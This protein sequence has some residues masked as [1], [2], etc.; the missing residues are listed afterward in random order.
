MLQCKYRSKNNKFCCN[1]AI[2]VN[3]I[4]YDRCHIKSH[5]TD[6]SQ[7]NSIKERLRENFISST[8]NINASNIINTRGDG[9]CLYRTM[10]K[11]LLDNKDTLKK[12][13]FIDVNVLDHED[14]DQE[15]YI[16]TKIQDE[17][18]NYIYENKSKFI[19]QCGELL[20]DVVMN[21]HNDTISDIEEYHELYKI[22]AGD[23]DYYYETTILDNGRKQKNKIEISDRWGS[24]AE[25]I[26]F[27]LRFGIE[28]N[29]FIIQ[30]FDERKIK[31]IEVTKRAKDIRLKLYQ[32]INPEFEGINVNH[33][34]PLNLIIEKHLSSPHYMYINNLE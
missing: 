12:Y 5:W 10:A 32:K 13:N 28:V 17:L 4:T 6:I 22:F 9:A 15:K 1:K 31:I 29:V 7:F 34:K 2:S 30:K 21:T 8:F 20:E 33:N 24:T 26:A 11:Y 23:N 25:Q 27:S 16:A 3:G 18:N 19:N 14:T